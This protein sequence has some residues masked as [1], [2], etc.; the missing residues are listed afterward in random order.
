M[1]ENSKFMKIEVPI[2]VVMW[3]Y[4]L[5]NFEKVAYASEL[6]HQRLEKG[7]TENVGGESVWEFWGTYGTSL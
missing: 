2:V 5:I 7:G 6:N 1:N 3:L 4:E